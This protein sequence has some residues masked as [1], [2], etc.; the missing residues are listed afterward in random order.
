MARVVRDDD[1]FFLCRLALCTDIVCDA[2][3]RT[4]DGIHVHTVRPGADDTSQ[5]GCAELQILNEALPDLLLISC[6]RFKLRPQRIVLRQ[7][8]HPYA[9]PF[10]VIHLF[11]LVLFV[12]PGPPDPPASALRAAGALFLLR[13]YPGT[14]CRASCITLLR[15]SRWLLRDS[16][17]SRRS[18]PAADC[19]PAR[20]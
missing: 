4:S 19:S 18:S 15:A 10:P 3:R 6:Q 8:F 17:A 2:L 7:L 5:T 9:V 1:A 16:R 20:A 13:A 14:L 12:Y 11:L